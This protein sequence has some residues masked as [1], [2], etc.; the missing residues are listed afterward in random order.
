MKKYEHING[1]FYT[2]EEIITYSVDYE[3][4]WTQGMEDNYL[5]L[6]GKEVTEAIKKAKTE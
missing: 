2:L 1:K 4:P 3:G 5:E 6:Y